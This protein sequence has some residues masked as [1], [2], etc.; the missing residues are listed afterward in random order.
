MKMTS[1][2]AWNTRGF[3]KMRKHYIVRHW[4][5]STKLFFGCLLE[6]RV[7]E[8]NY[9]RIFEYMFTGWK[10]ETNYEYHRLGRIWVCWKD[11]TTVQILYKS[12]QIIT[13]WVTSGTGAQFMVSCIYAS[14]FNVDRAMLWEEIQHNN[15][16][17]VKGSL[18]WILMG[19]FNETLST[20]EHSRG[21]SIQATG[22]M[23]SFQSLISNCEFSDLAYVGPTFTWWNNHEANPIGK[24]L[25]RALIN[26][27]WCNVNLFS[28]ATFETCGMSDHCRGSVSLTSSQTHTH[29]PFKYF[30]DIG[31]LP[32]FNAKVK[33]AWES[34][35]NL[36]YSR[37]ALYLF[38]KKLK[39]LKPILQALNKDKYGNITSKAREAFSELCAT[40]NRA[41]LAPNSANL[42]AVSEATAI[43]DHLAAIEERFFWQ[44]SRLTW[45][46]CGDQNMTFSTEQCKLMP[47]EIRLK[48][49]L[50]HK[51]E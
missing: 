5:S 32:L 37:S 29:L 31:D 35:D 10:V 41:L 36:Y 45:I 4:C 2:F 3:N 19:G 17:F 12:S 26:G 44:K 34:S 48:G 50:P 24:K 27:S 40:Q 28:F 43:W 38:H 18:P 42:A 9:S 25:D 51:D 30:S 6:T 7:K 16:L 22:G 49:S 11:D 8:E 33:E 15:N 23:R 13:C 1:I 46:Q 20:S 47:P 14:N 39:A 21:M